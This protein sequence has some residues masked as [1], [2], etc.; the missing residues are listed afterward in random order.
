MTVFVA[1]FFTSLVVLGALTFVGLT[2]GIG[3]FSGSK[4]GSGVQ[5]V[6]AVIA[7]AWAIFCTNYAGMLAL[8]G[9]VA[10]GVAIALVVFFK[11]HNKLRGTTSTHQENQMNKPKTNSSAKPSTIAETSDSKQAGP[12]IDAVKP[13]ASIAV[14]SKLKVSAAKLKPYLDH[15]K[16]STS[17]DVLIV[18]VLR[19]GMGTTDI[20][21]NKTVFIVI[22]I[23]FT[24]NQDPAIDGKVMNVGFS[25]LVTIKV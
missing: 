10:A 7:T 9:V 22:E 15:H 20:N 23:V 5:F 12:A 11:V 24:D 19:M 18:E 13:V 14:G 25:D 2:A 4:R 16:L 17:K 6:C 8:A 1:S 21:P 3:M